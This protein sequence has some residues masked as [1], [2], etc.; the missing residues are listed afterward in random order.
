MHRTAGDTERRYHLR[1][2]KTCPCVYETDS[3]GHCV[4][5][6]LH[7]AFAHGPQDLRKPIYDIREIQ[8]AEMGDGETVTES[9]L[10]SSLETDRLL[11]EDPV[12]NSMI[13]IQLKLVCRGFIYW[14]NSPEPSWGSLQ[15]TA[16]LPKLLLLVTSKWVGWD[17]V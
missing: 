8:A 16:M 4:K 15:A 12:W 10:T 7:C 2:Y 1:Y 11:N 14:I 3:K 9:P 17:G 6:G 13:I 5:N